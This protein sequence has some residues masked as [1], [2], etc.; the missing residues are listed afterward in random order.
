MPLRSGPKVYYKPRPS[1]EDYILDRSYRDATSR[2]GYPVREARRVDEILRMDKFQ[3]PL[4]RVPQEQSYPRPAIRVQERRDPRDPHGP[5]RST[6]DHK[7][8]G[9][10][11][12]DDLYEGVKDRFTIKKML[13]RVIDVSLM[14]GPAK[15]I[16][17]ALDGLD[18]IVASL[19][20]FHPEQPLNEAYSNYY[21]SSKC[22]NQNPAPNRYVGS[23]H[24]PNYAAGCL[25]GQALTT[26]PDFNS[27]AY[28]ITSGRP[29]VLK[30]YEYLTAGGALRN[31][32]RLQWNKLPR[33]KAVQAVD[34]SMSFSRSRNANSQRYA[35]LTPQ[36][37]QQPVSRPGQAPAVQ[38]AIVVTVA[39]GGAS[40]PPR[41]QNFRAARSTPPPKGTKEI[42]S[43]AG[44][45]AAKIADILDRVSEGSE[46]IDAIYQ[47]LP[48]DVKKRWEKGRD[49]DRQGDSMGQ[50]GLAGA[51]WKIQAIW[52]NVLKIDPS[53]A[54][55]NILL[56]E[57]EDKLYGAAFKAKS[58]VTARGR[59]RK[60]GPFG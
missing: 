35:N 42:K 57:L 48:S 16:G 53:E 10:V 40:L 33:H 46:V 56:N 7:S 52:H 36:P 5:H 50:Y 6:I 3:G 2:A 39:S 28:T 21:F 12:L 15:P 32:I 34:G 26:Y 51:D 37:L 47:A 41:V 11:T 18:V 24:P 60:R 44:K 49:L 4:E 27:A 8:K 31:A 43:K 14:Y 55:R 38:Q 30:T 54:L 29:T 9:E 19:P 25:S 1:Y 59:H 17:F 23:S 22:A 58:H 20:F 45:F 13:D